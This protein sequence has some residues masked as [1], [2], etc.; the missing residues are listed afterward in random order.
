MKRIPASHEAF[1]TASPSDKYCQHHE[2]R[3]MYW[4]KIIGT[5]LLSKIYPTTLHLYKE[6]QSILACISTLHG[7]K[8]HYTVRN[9]RSLDLDKTL[10]AHFRN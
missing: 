2:E 3:K 4:T 1:R 5:V 7:R 8:I 10:T 6:Y 9:D